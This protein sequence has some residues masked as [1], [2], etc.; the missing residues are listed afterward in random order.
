[1]AEDVSNKELYNIINRAI[2]KWGCFDNVPADKEINIFC[3][4]YD[5]R[6]KSNPQISIFEDSLPSAEEVKI[7]KQ[8][9]SD[10]ETYRKSI[11]I[12][13]G[14][15]DE[16]SESFYRRLYQGL[17]RYAEHVSE[18]NQVRYKTLKQ[19]LQGKLPEFAEKVLLDKLS[20]EIDIIK[21]L[22]KSKSPEYKTKTTLF[23][24]QIATQNDDLKDEI[25]ALSA[26]PEK[27][28]FCKSCIDIVDYL[29][30]EKYTRSAKFTLK[31]NLY[32]LISKTARQMGISHTTIVA[33]NEEGRFQRAK[34]KAIQYAKDPNKRR[35]RKSILGIEE[36]NRRAMEEWIYK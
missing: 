26:T 19:N 9:C 16:L 25:K 6:R 31:S 23:F 7:A 5:M 28:A 33:K 36:R 20:Q 30:Q 4:K 3:H 35:P 1:M 29:P 21:Y 18:E 8:L 22:K 11:D 10:I 2:S 13:E 17:D 14:T 24:K 15:T 34:E 32:N 12:Y 27:I